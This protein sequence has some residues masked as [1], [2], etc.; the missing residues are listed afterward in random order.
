MENSY[1]RLRELDSLR[2]LAALTVVIGHCLL[3]VDKS[4]LPFYVRYSPLRILWS[5][6]EAVILFFIISGL[7]L[8]K[9]YLDGRKFDY[10][11]FILKRVTRIYIPYIVSIF[12]AIVMREFFF[13]NKGV[14]GL[15][16]WFDS[17]WTD[18][19][20]L[21]VIVNHL[22][23]IGDFDTSNL[24]TVIWTLVHEMRIA[25][26]FPLILFMVRRF[27]WRISIIASVVLSAIGMLNHLFGLQPGLGYRN[28]YFDTVHYSI[29]FIFGSL[30]AKHL[31]KLISMYKSLTRNKKLLLIGV[32]F[33]FY[34]YGQA[35]YY[36]LELPIKDFIVEWVVGIGGILLVILALTSSIFQKVLSTRLM[37]GIGSLSYSIYLYH[38]TVLFSFIYALYNILPIWIIILIAIL[39]TFIVATISYRLIELPSIKLG[40]FLA[41]RLTTQSK[42]LEVNNNCR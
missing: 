31:N 40:K 21:Q 17:K 30:I 14:N 7:V 38:I 19:V 16:E 15:G 5:G 25:F 6:H 3:I 22:L 28:S 10:P 12:F 9:P 24:N 37:N 11:S 2:G 42:A 36:V 26:F 29:F 1:T 18:S 34:T 4:I 41:K 27:N 23:L 8:S 32:T 33:I 13:K 35:I 20:D 39:F